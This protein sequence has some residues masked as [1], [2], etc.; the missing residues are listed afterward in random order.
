MKLVMID[1]TIDRNGKGSSL[2]IARIYNR[3]LIAGLRTGY[4]QQGDD[5][6][7]DKLFNHSLMIY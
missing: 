7:I 1:F 3:F 4:E 6:K 5:D 2:G